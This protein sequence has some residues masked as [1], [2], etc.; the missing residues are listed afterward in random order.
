MLFRSAD[1]ASMI[2]V[3]LDS[4]QA[5][6]SRRSI[7]SVQGGVV[8]A[9]PDGLCLADANGVK[10]VSGAMFTR[11]DW[12]ALSPSTMFGIEHE[13]VCYIF[14]SGGCLTFDV[15]AG[16]LGRLDLTATAA[17]V[18]RTT[19]TLYVADGTAIKAVFGAATR[20]TGKWKSAK[21]VLDRKSTR[22][23]S[24]H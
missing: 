6:V 4:N 5:C 18:D 24:S 10:V 16:K 9:S 13:E 7:V 14:Y 22:L 23:N 17:F 1:S 8:F 21:G 19:D 11:E 3:K 15:G 20:R 12:Q 2:A